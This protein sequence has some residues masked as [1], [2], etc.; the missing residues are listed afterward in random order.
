LYDG[1]QAKILR[2]KLNK[3]TLPTLDLDIESTFAIDIKN[4]LAGY[5]KEDEKGEYSF[6]DKV[7][8]FL[9]L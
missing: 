4:I 9:K 3:K 5:L 8:H 1:S 2:L 6:T 7:I